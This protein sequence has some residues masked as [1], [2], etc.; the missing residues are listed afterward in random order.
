MTSVRSLRSPLRAP[1]SFP[2]KIILVTVFLQKLFP[3]K[4]VL[5]VFFS[6]PATFCFLTLVWEL[7]GYGTVHVTQR[8]VLCLYAKKTLG[9]E[10]YIF[11][12]HGNTAW[13]ELVRYGMVLYVIWYMARLATRHGAMYANKCRLEIDPGQ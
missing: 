12:V 11:A 8:S 10:L 13:R 7:V 5:T 3:A 1:E 2:A 4:K 6:P 9:E